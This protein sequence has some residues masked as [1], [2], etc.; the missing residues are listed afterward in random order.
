M[1]ETRQYE[2]VYVAAPDLTEDGVAELHTQVEEIVTDLG[3]RIEKTDNW[4]RRRLAYEIGKYREGT[5]VVE[6]IEG[7]GTIV[8]ELDRRL[9]VRDDVLRHLVVRVDEDLKKARRSREKRQSWQQ[10]RRAARGLP[11]IPEQ[12]AVT[13]TSADGSAVAAS[14]SESP[15]VPSSPA[16][17]TAVDPPTPPAEAAP[18]A[19][20]TESAEAEVKQ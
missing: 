17:A 1:S 4:G 10:R 14:A 6:L 7:P 19:A 12:T 5:Y 3:G 18:V 16:P 15:A 9:K 11:P 13:A 2:L 8:S 20:D